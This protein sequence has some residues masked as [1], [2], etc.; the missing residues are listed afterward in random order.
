M[1]HKEG[2]EAPP[3]T[4][5][6]A[7]LRFQGGKEPSRESSDAGGCSLSPFSFGL[8][9]LAARGAWGAP[10]VPWGAACVH[11]QPSPGRSWF[12]EAMQRHRAISNKCKML[13]PLSCREEM[14]GGKKGL[15]FRRESLL[16][17]ELVPVSGSSLGPGQR[18]LRERFGAGSG[19]AAGR[20]IRAA[21]GDRA[22]AFSPSTAP[23][24][25]TA[26][27]LHRPA[28]GAQ[29][30]LGL[31]ERGARERQH[32][33]PF[34]RRRVI[35]DMRGGPLSGPILYFSEGFASLPSPPLCRCYCTV[36]MGRAPRAAAMRGSAGEGRAP[37]PDPSGAPQPRCRQ[38]PRAAPLT[39][40]GPGNGAFG[41][42]KFTATGGIQ[43]PGGQ[44]DPGRLAPFSLPLRLS[45]AA[46][47]SAHTDP[48]V[49][50]SS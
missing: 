9:M 1:R 36:A 28:H 30:A 16:Q 3:R 42:S 35:Y 32:P 33:S 27:L 24:G 13:W 40:R 23:M 5:F 39:C 29:R 17:Q 12:G 19:A 46:V 6:E 25:A 8:M 50:F 7:S 38:H 10:R 48:P 31:W 47:S 22:E 26:S 49:P 37:R 18:A 4:G 34:C 41:P 14:G 11:P 44:R 43:L 21:G 2:Q 15:F 20:R 45:A